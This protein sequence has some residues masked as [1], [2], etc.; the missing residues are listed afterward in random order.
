MNRNSEDVES[1]TDIDLFRRANDDFLDA[2]KDF[3][4]LRFPDP[5]IEKVIEVRCEDTP[6]KY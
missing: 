4:P 6:T 2:K 1:S 5:S 3:L